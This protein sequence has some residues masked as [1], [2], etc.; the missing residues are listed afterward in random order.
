VQRRNDLR[1][2]PHL[3]PFVPP[4]IMRAGLS[5]RDKRYRYQVKTAL[6]PVTIYLN[7]RLR[8]WRKTSL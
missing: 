2:W 3:A 4:A 6:R 7:Y 1:G 8:L 5:Q